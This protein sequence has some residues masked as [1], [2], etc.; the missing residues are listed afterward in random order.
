M[1]NL[2]YHDEVFARQLRDFVPKS[3]FFIKTEKSALSPIGVADDG[4][5]YAAPTKKES[6]KKRKSRKLEFLTSLLDKMMTSI[7]QYSNKV[8]K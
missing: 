6:R 5:V 3:D 4:S 7:T 1:F 8:Q 2:T